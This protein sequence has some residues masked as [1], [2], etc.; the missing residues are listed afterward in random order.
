MCH[1]LGTLWVSGFP[2]AVVLVGSYNQYLPSSTLFHLC[3]L[4]T[5]CSDMD[6]KFTLP[7]E[8]LDSQWDGDWAFQPENDAVYGGFTAFNEIGLDVESQFVVPS[9]KSPPHDEATSALTKLSAA[10]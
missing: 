2:R 1:P 6:D 4:C 7:S 10:S 3:T 9:I 5:I 8:A